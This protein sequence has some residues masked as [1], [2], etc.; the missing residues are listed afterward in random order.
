M[1]QDF[2][3]LGLDFNNKCNL[4]KKEIRKAFLEKAKEIHPD[5]NSSPDAK[6]QFQELYD[7]YQRLLNK[8]S[9]SNSNS[10]S[11]STS[12]S[13]STSNSTSNSNSN[14]TST[15]TSFSSM[16]FDKYLKHW[17]TIIFGDD[18]PFYIQHGIEPTGIF[19]PPYN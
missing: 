12:T 17:F 13:T 3:L 11:T 10:Y 4:K 6:K 9:F 8:N 2:K 1:E 14:S 5:H 16:V 19:G 7:A 18:M 15:S